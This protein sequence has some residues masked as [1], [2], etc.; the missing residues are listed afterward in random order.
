MTRRRARGRRPSDDGHPMP[1]EEQASL[2]RTALVDARAL[3]PVLLDM[4]DVTTITDYFL[5]CHGTSN[6]HIR[7]LADAL[8]DGLDEQGL[9]PYGL[10]GYDD[11]RWILLDYGDLIVHIFAE[12]ERDFYDLERLWSDAARVPAPAAEKDEDD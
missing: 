5:I 10:E 6:V 3:E 8:R 4:R 7:G 12:E 11:A 9:R 1:A 2:A